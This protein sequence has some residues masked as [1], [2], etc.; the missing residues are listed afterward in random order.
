MSTATATPEAKSELKTLQ[1]V[2]RFAFLKL[3]GN[4]NGLERLPND[5]IP[6]I[7]K[8]IGATFKKVNESI[9]SETLIPLTKDELEIL[10]PMKIGTDI[11]DR[12]K[13]NVDVENFWREF[14]IL[15]TG[16]TVRNPRRLN[17]SYVKQE[18]ILSDGR[19]VAINIPDNLDDWFAYKLC[20]KNG[21]VASTKEDRE[22]RNFW[23][24]LEDEQ[25][26][27]REEEQIFTLKLAADDAYI[28]ITNKVENLDTFNALLIVFKEIYPTN[29]PLNTDVRKKMFLSEIKDKYPKL[30]LE[31]IKDE[32]LKIKAYIYELVESRILNLVNGIYVYDNKT[33]GDL[34]ETIVYFNNQNN[35]DLSVI[36]MLFENKKQS[37]K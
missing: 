15:V 26:I 33:L 8:Y 10:M 5:F 35:K 4:L 21:L 9:T 27:I 17:I 6:E 32:N 18:V 13:F 3:N 37:K 22:S 25:E 24:I 20:K 12:S 16:E 23:F 1:R 19:K 29:R 30:F 14:E 31:T 11:K 28:N 7:K 34:E 36:K 2:E